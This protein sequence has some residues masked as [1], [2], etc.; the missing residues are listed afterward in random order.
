MS[1][2]IIAFPTI[3]L[4]QIRCMHVSNNHY[5]TLG[6]PIDCSRRDIK[7]AYLRKVMLLHPDRQSIKKQA[8]ASTETKSHPSKHITKDEFL[9]VAQAYQVLSNPK[10]RQQYDTDSIHSNT[11][12]S[13]ETPKPT[14]KPPNHPEYNPY[15]RSYRRPYGWTADTYGYG[16]E[17]THASE[18]AVK[19]NTTPKYMSHTAM[20]LLVV[21][22][23]WIVGLGMVEFKTRLWHRYS[24]ESRIEQLRNNYLNSLQPVESDCK[25]D[26]QPL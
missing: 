4:N 5:K 9:R 8:T 26:S 21:V 18:A 6:L 7:Q 25:P 1:R 3:V 16:H 15:T 20:S 19:A 11:S 10:S 17:Y 23:A 24:E 12:H 22:S 2:Q 13:S 14:W